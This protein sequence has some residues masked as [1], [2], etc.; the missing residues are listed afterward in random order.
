MLRSFIMKTLGMGALAAAIIAALASLAGDVHGQP[1][2]AE[3]RALRQQLH[4]DDARIDSL[5]VRLAYLK[6]D[7]AIIRTSPPDSLSARLAAN[8]WRYRTELAALTA[9]DYSLA[10][11]AGSVIAGYSWGS[12]RRDPGG[13]ADSW[14]TMDK[15]AHLGLASALTFAGDAAGMKTWQAG[16]LVCVAGVAFE[17]GQA[18]GGGFVSRKDIGANCIGAALAA[19]WSYLW[20]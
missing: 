17:Y 5:E 13:Y 2:R 1:A 14:G 15:Y 12:V 7:S 8:A 9:P 4:A 10:L 20:R 11:L 19:G 18:R 16:A 6:R 3:I